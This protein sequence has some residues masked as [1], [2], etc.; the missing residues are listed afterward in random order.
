M[1]RL[2]TISYLSIIYAV[3]THLIQSRGF[4]LLSYYLA[5]A[6]SQAWARRDGVGAGEV[7]CGMLDFR[8]VGASGRYLLLLQELGNGEA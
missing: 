8:V 7:S 4:S 3:L 1:L 2:Q 6:L 5:Y